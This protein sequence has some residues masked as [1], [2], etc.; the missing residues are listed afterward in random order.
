MR[1]LVSLG[2]LVGI[3]STTFV[4]C[5][6]SSRQY[7]LINPDIK[8]VD[9][10][11]K[12]DAVNILNNASNSVES[13][14]CS[15]S[16]NSITFKPRWGDKTVSYEKV[17]FVGTKGY[18]PS[19]NSMLLSYYDSSEKI[20]YICGVSKRWTNNLDS[21]TYINALDKLGILIEYNQR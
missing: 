13:S 12:S 9:A 2:I 6:G 10:L 1:K 8:K 17:S 21:Q 11:S 3:I 5:G 15:Y 20:R 14:K 19:Q 18:N 7:M 4:A 16:E